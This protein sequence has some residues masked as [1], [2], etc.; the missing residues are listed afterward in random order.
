MK[1]RDTNEE[2]GQTKAQ[3]ENGGLAIGAGLSS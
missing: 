3:V 1:F 2:V